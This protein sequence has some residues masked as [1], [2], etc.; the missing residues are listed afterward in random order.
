MAGQI[1]LELASGPLTLEPGGAPMAATL[2]VRNDGDVVDEVV[3]HVEG[4]DSA[5]FTLA[6]QSVRLFPGEHQE[7]SLTVH[8]P[9][10]A[11]AGPRVFRVVG[12]SRARPTDSAALTVAVQVNRVTGPGA[13][14]LDLLPIRQRVRGSRAASY[15]VRVRNQDNAPLA[16]RLVAIDPL[17][18]LTLHVDP[19][20]VVVPAGGET[21]ARLRA[22]P[23][24]RVLTGI[25]RVFEFALS[26]VADDDPVAPPLARVSGQLVDAPWLV[27]FG[28]LLARPT[29]GLLLGALPLLVA[30][31]VAAWF[32][33]D[34]ASAPV[35]YR[36]D[37]RRQ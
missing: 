1:V 26:G 31:V 15:V 7:V 22:T 34:R 2:V 23:R 28:Q 11:E 18:A 8:A 13:A 37:L 17:D 4:L 33:V 27:P 19:D 6:E 30:A 12:A 32:V 29:R 3:L 35:A 36:P 25:E 5:W 20:L 14:T 16:L 24:H 21:T 10:D 9:V